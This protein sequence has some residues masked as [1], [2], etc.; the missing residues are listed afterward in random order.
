MF[1]RLKAP[2]VRPLLAVGLGGALAMAIPALPAVGV[3][4][5]PGVPHY[6]EI[7]SA[8]LLAKGAA[9][10]VS[11]E[12]VCPAGSSAFVSVQVSQARGRHV[13]RG[14]D[15]TSV[16]CTGS[17]QTVELTVFA[18]EGAFKKGTAIA[19][20]FLQA[21]TFGGPFPEPPTCVSGSDTEQV[22]IA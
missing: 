13:A 2:W 9:A 21:C 3:H 11:V 7:E 4:S 12:V 14:G 22:S 10:T 17:L 1:E 20:A 8:D 6:I 19:E 5:P 15:G 16:A 18:T